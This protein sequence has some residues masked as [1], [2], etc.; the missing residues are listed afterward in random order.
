MSF[1]TRLKRGVEFIKICVCVC[2]CEWVSVSKSGEELG[3]FA[4]Q[5]SDHIIYSENTVYFKSS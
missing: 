5:T 2:Q 1:E 4:I 3:T